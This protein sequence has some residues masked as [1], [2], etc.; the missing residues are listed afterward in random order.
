MGGTR[1]SLLSRHS[2]FVAVLHVRAS[3][4]TSCVTNHARKDTAH[5]AYETDC[6]SLNKQVI[7]N[8]CDNITLSFPFSFPGQC[9]SSTYHCIEGR[10]CVV[11]LCIH[12]LPKVSHPQF[13]L[14]AYPRIPCLFPRR[15]Q[16]WCCRH[17]GGQK[18]AK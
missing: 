4:L 2:S 16:S 10:S 14:T 8:G 11:V 15:R 6:H 5:A 17:I 1:L 7:K 3:L 18:M 12:G 13:A 9:T